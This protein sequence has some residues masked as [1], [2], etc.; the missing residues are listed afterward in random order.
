M[1]SATLTQALQQTLGCPQPLTLHPQ[2]GGCISTTGLITGSTSPMPLAFLKVHDASRITMF[3]AEADA[4]SR[5]SSAVPAATLRFPHP[6]GSGVADSRAWLLLEPLHLHAVADADTASRLGSALAILH[7]VSSPDGR[8][9]WHQD[10]TIGST[11][12]RNSW[13]HDWAAFFCD[14]RLAPQLELAA[15][16]GYRFQHADALLTRVPLLLSGH[17]PPASL[18]HGDLWSGNAAHLADGTPV[19]FDPASY[20]GDRETDIAFTQLFGGFPAAFYRAY[21][22]SWPLP[23]GHE[24]RATLYNLYHLLNHLHLFGASYAAPVERSIQILLTQS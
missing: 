13:T 5:L 7:R 3:E 9:G 20:Y 10:N 24:V 23:A 2:G 12:Q 4:L 19:L 6:I 17:H 1:L 14:H 11:P 22:E 21:Q 18:L 8:F 16:N 15:S